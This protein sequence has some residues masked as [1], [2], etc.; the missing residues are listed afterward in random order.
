M[1]GFL[2]DTNVLSELSRKEPDQRVRQWLSEADDDQVFTSALALAEIRFGIEL[3]SPGRRRS[4]LQHWFEGEL[5]IYFSGRALP[6][7]QSVADGWAVLS[8]QMQKKGR[9][10]AIVDGLIAATAAENGLT[11]VTRDINDFS[12][13][14]VELLNPWKT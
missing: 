8:A 14:G 7:T 5:L 6:V 12:D 10:V 4:D 1:S 11:V 9:R 3:L 13:L 2:V